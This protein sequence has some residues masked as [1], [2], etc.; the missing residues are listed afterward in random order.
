MGKKRGGW[1]NPLCRVVTVFIF[2]HHDVSELC[3]QVAAAAAV[4]AGRKA[5]ASGDRALVYVASDE[6]DEVMA[7][8]D[9]SSISNISFLNSHDVREYFERNGVDAALLPMVMLHV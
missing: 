3:A 6:V 8:I 7:Y 4:E 5:A 2:R 9:S 1:L